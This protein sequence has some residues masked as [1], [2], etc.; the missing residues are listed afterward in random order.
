MPDLHAPLNAYFA[1][2]STRRLLRS[3]P[4]A[5]LAGGSG[6]VLGLIVASPAFAATGTAIILG[7]IAINVVSSL[8]EQLVN[9]PL[10]AE[11]ERE[12]LIERGLT[13]GDQ[14]VLAA[15]AAALVQ[16]GPEVA[17]ALPATQRAELID[18]LQHGMAQAGGPL[19]A[20]APRYAAALS[21]EQADWGNLREA[22]RQAISVRLSDEI[23]DEARV[24]RSGQRVE[25]PTGN[26][27]VTRKVGKG[28]RVEDSGQTVIGGNAPAA[29]ITIERAHINVAGHDTV[30][31]DKVGNDKLGGDKVLGD[32]DA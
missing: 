12:A 9:L 2:S 19:A 25:H 21:E 15:V 17:R 28:A 11:T 22:L 1:E 14:S 24:I 8:L 23:G 32:K 4:I 29:P 10:E 6:I 26:V 20:I 16:A 31:G 18:G 30:S 3:A 7:G 13:Q 5:A 27:E